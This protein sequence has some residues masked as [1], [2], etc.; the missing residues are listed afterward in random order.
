MLTQVPDSELLCF[1]MPLSVALRYDICDPDTTT[2]SSLSPALRSGQG[3]GGY[4]VDGGE[5]EGEGGGGS[6]I[7]ARPAGL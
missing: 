1:L 5:G 7:G 2:S 4:D 3:G 6:L